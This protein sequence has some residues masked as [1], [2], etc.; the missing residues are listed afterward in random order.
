MVEKKRSQVIRPYIVEVE[1]EE[2]FHQCISSR[3][4]KLFCTSQ[5]WTEFLLEISHWTHILR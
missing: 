1:K 2:T 3:C 5:I 4:S